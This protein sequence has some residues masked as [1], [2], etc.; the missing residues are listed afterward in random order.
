MHG[1]GHQ[2][3]LHGYFQQ[4]A[5]GVQVVDGGKIFAPLPFVDGLRI[6][7]S[8]VFLEVTDG[9]SPFLAESGDVRAGGGQVDDRESSLIH[10]QHLLYENGSRAF[11]L[12]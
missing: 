1:G 4:H 2:D 12:C 10:V 8:E 9:Q 11:A 3:V 7:E 5:E 6:F